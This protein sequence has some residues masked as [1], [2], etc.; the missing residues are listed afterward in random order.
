MK[1]RGTPMHRRSALSLLASAVLLGCHSQSVESPQINLAWLTAT[2]ASASLV[3][4]GDSVAA[5]LTVTNH[6]SATQRVEFAPCTYYGPLSLR[7]YRS[8]VL[9]SPAW[10]SA[11][12]DN[13]A[14]FTSLEFVDLKA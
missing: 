7:A 4:T 1:S 12:D 14:C 6:G 8:G 13:A 3:A 10:D 9:T 11:L 2:A 5:S